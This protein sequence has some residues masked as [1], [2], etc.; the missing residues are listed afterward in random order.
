MHVAVEVPIHIPAF[1]CHSPLLNVT[2]FDALQFKPGVYVRT[3]EP[4]LPS[5]VWVSSVWVLAA[6][7]WE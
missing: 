4:Q 7:C 2:C 5:V 1:F 3:V 6:P